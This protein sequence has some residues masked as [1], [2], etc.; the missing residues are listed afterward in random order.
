MERRQPGSLALRKLM[1][2]WG[3]GAENRHKTKIIWGEKS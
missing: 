3:T 2:S 1:I